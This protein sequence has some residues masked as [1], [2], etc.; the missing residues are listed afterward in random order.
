MPSEYKLPLIRN[1]RYYLRKICG[2]IS[3]KRIRLQ[4]LWE[5]EDKISYQ[6]ADWELLNQALTHKS[7]A[8]EV[9]KNNIKHYEMLEFLG[10][11]VLDMVISHLLMK[12][13]PEATEGELSKNRSSLVNTKRLSILA[14]QFGLGHYILL[15]KGEEQSQGRSKATILTCVYEALIGA[16][17]LDGGFKKVARVIH[18]HFEQLLSHKLSKGIYRDFK[19]RLQEYSQGTF[20]TIPEYHLLSESGPPHAKE[21]AIHIKINGKGYGSGRGKSKKEAQQRAAMATLKQLGVSANSAE[22]RKQHP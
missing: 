14:G 18:S 16:I 3:I 22:A 4:K 6:F 13:Y 19:S 17:Y 2:E 7:Y 21:F 12:K 10:D 11:A 9:L 8:Y 20:K 15:G 1:F 5:L